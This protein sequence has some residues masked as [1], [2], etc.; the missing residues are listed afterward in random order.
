MFFKVGFSD[1]ETYCYGQETNE[2][3]NNLISNKWEFNNL[4]S[5]YTHHPRKILSTVHNWSIKVTILFPLEQREKQKKETIERERGI[6]SEIELILL[7]IP[8]ESMN[9]SVRTFPLCGDDK[10]WRWG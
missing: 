8:V 10:E 3:L 9:L 2:I 6:A 4:F 1:G 5:T 7:Q